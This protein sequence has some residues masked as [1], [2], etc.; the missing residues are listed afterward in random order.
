M[1]RWLQRLTTIAIIVML[2]VSKALALISSAFS[3][4]LSGA[5]AGVAGIK[6]IS[7][8]NRETLDRQ[9]NAVKR[10]GR[11]MKVRTRRIVARNTVRSTVTWI[12]V[13]GPPLRLPSLHGNW[14]ITASVYRTWRLTG[15]HRLEHARPVTTLDTLLAT[16][17]G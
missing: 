16:Y 7:Q 12:P 8:I 4:V 17:P 3:A 14:L 10:M 9:Q 2:L 15:K 11:R 5:V 1:I 6:T 13:L